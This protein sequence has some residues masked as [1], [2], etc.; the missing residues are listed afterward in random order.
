MHISDKNLQAYY[1]REMDAVTLSEVAAHLEDCPHCQNRLGA[2]QSRAGWVV[3]KMAALDPDYQP[4]KDSIVQARRQLETRL[5]SPKEKNI[6]KKVNRSAVAAVV[7]LI[8][9]V[10]LF[11]FPSVRAAAENFLGLF[12]V[13]KIQVVSFNPVNLPQDFDERLVDIENLMLDSLTVTTGGE[14]VE[15]AD[16][17]A[18]SEMAGFEVRVPVGADYII[19]YQPASQAQFVIDRALMNE[20]LNSIGDSQIDIPRSLD[21]QTV[22]INVPN[23]VTFMSGDC[24]KSLDEVERP[25]GGFSRDCTV[26]AQLPSPT[27][28]APAG[29]P[30]DRIGRMLLELLGMSP[31]DAEAFSSQVDWSTTLVLP[32]PSDANVSEVKVNGTDA[33]LF[34]SPLFERWEQGRY[35]SFQLMWVEDGIVYGLSMSGQY[36][37]ED[38]IATAES[39][40][41]I[42]VP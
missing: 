14:P 34:A 32:V 11:A 35:Q 6:M 13:Q 30:I 33:T 17:A 5:N 2:V 19:S 29:L 40:K 41:R 18:A 36:R 1:N 8:L 10:A 9:V 26:L 25:A 27:I 22:T 42:M 3:E 16:A 7:A 21:G 24:T 12:R 20:L 4:S 23:S 39:L 31:E 28:D 37:A 15:V 38:V